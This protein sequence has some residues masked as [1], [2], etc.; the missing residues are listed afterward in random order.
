VK[1]IEMK[2]GKGMIKMNS[3]LKENKTIWTFTV[4]V[5]CSF[6]V[7]QL[8]SKAHLPSKMQERKHTLGNMCN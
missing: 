1:H 2:I 6:A 3:K 4:I 7:C 8:E 5:D